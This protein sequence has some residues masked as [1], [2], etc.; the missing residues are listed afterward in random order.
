MKKREKVGE[1]KREKGEEKSFPPASAFAN[2]EKY[3][4]EATTVMGRFSK[5]FRYVIVLFVL[6]RVRYKS[7]TYQST[8]KRNCIILRNQEFIYDTYE[9]CETSSESWKERKSYSYVVHKEFVT[10]SQI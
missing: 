6:F 7:W 8:N 5:R 1:E 10:I 2:D 3:S 9:K 4:Y